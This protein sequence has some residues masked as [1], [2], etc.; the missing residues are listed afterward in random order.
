[1]HQVTNNHPLVAFPLCGGD[2]VP[3]QRDQ[4]DVA[5]AGH[6]LHLMCKGGVPSRGAVLESLHCHLGTVA[7]HPL[8]DIPKA[9]V[10]DNALPGEPIGG[11]LD[12]VV[13]E[14]DE[15][16]AGADGLHGLRALAPAVCGQCSSGSSRLPPPHDEA[17][18]HGCGEE[19]H[20]RE[21][22]E[23][24]AV[25]PGGGTGAVGLRRVRLE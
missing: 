16:G 10:A 25:D 18:S 17:A 23:R 1:V 21:G 7:Q 12:I 11:S 2:A 6:H 8:V 22:A 9:T 19:Q 5:H 24:D 13:G 14:L 3:T 20:C 15:R 4:V